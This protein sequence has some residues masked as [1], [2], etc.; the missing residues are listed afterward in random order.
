MVYDSLRSQ[1]QI[2][3]SLVELPEEC[4][5]CAFK[6]NEICRGIPLCLRNLSNV[7]IPDFY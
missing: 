5:K 1:Y 2:V 4:K 7:D 6:E 3:N